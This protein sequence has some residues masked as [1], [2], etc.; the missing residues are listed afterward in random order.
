MNDEVL[1]SLVDI[2]RVKTSTILNLS[3]DHSNQDIPHC[4]V[5]GIKIPANNLL[6]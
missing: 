6:V 2:Y 3:F 5:I 1:H 4:Y